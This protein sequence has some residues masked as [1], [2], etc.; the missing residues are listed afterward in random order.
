MREIQKL[1][2]DAKMHLM[3]QSA[4]L[5]KKNQGGKLTSQRISPV[6]TKVQGRHHG[7]TEANKFKGSEI[8][9]RSI[10]SIQQV[11]T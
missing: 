2:D 8:I 1:L 7:K 4:N 10:K 6:K 3:Q 5:Q 11:F 9:P